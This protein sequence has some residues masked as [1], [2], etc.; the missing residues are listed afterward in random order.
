[1][2]II[3][4][5]LGIS[6]FIAGLFLWSNIIG[7]LFG[8]IPIASKLKRQGIIKREDYSLLKMLAPVVLPLIIF[9]LSYFYFRIFLY[10][11]LISLVLILLSLGKLRQEAYE[12]LINE[13]VQ[14]EARVY[15]K[16]EKK[17]TKNSK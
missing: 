6:G 3:T 11:S 16:K 13:Q 1:M 9:V 12:N 2:N 8:T 5:A 17:K 15:L 7:S 14:N 10:A 4:I